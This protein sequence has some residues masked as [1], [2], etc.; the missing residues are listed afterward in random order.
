MS[1]TSQHPE[2]STRLADWVLMR[3]SHKG[4]RQIKDKGTLYLS[5]TPGQEYDGMQPSQPGKK[6]YDAYKARARYHDFI[7]QAVEALIGVMHHKPPNIELPKKMEPL[8]E[9]GTVKGEPL[10][11]LLRRINTEQLITGR[12]GLLADVPDGSPV[13]TLPYVATYVAE[14][15]LNWDDGRREE[16]SL[17]NLNLVVLDES[18][19]ERVSMFDW[20]QEQKTRVL[21]LG[22]LSA[23][24]P[25]MQGLYRQAVFAG[26]DTDFNESA[27]LVPSIGGRVLNKIPFVFVNA[28]DIV[29]ETDAPPLLGLA[30]LAL[31]VYRAEADYRQTLFMQG[32]DTLVIKGMASGGSNDAVGEDDIRAGAGATIYVSEEGDAKYIGVSSDGLREQRE[33]LQNDKKEAAEIGGKLLDTRGKEAE[34]GDAL[35]IRVSARTASLNQ[36][37]LAGAEGLKSIL[38]TIAE[39]VGADPEGVVVEPNLD[40]ADDSLDGRTLVDIMTAK[41]M[42]APIS[43]RTIHNTMKEKDMTELEFEEELAEIESEEPELD[44]TDEG[45]DDETVPGNEQVVGEDGEEDE[46]GEEG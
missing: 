17:Q 19:Y 40:F 14:D 35:R 39:W 20:R 32:Q 10:D 16:I 28:K 33:S 23:N 6:N 34:S 7:V 2:Y 12:V 5:A 1:L 26:N 3:D 15:I 45:G 43:L 41:T 9:R 42:G 37:A 22:D 8:L 11:V 13:S 36:I 44:G 27:L 24:E 4:E 21:V 18:E 29:P 38:K 30:N 31:T 46:T 25:E